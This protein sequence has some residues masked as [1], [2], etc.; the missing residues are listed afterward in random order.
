MVKEKLDLN[1]LV[2]DIE[3]E[4]GQKRLEG[5]KRDPDNYQIF[6]IAI[7]EN[8]DK[9]VKG[10][11]IHDNITSYLITKGYFGV[12][13]AK[14]SEGRHRYVAYCSKCGKYHPYTYQECPKCHTPLQ[15]VYRHRHLSENYDERYTNAYQPKWN[16]RDTTMDIAIQ[17]FVE[18][19]ENDKDRYV[20]SRW[21]LDRLD[22]KVD[23]YQAQIAVEMGVGQS[24]VA[25]RV[26]QLKKAFQIWYRY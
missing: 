18:S 11:E 8:I 23:N 21:M 3:R 9:A 13:H 14:V 17:D 20:A 10:L 5:L 25:R 26:I 22:L 24:C 19:I 16:D 4:L 2:Q 6:W 15:Y 12:K 7:L 1:K